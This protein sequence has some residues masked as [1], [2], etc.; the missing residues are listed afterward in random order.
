[1]IDAV[2]I[3]AIAKADTAACLLGKDH[4]RD[5][6]GLTAHAGQ[7]GDPVTLERRD[8]ARVLL[9][10]VIHG[11]QLCLGN[12]GLHPG[13]LIPGLELVRRDVD[14]RLDGLALVLEDDI[15][16]A[17]DGIALL[18]GQYFFFVRLVQQHAGEER[19]IGQM[20]ALLEHI[21]N[22]PVF[23]CGES[24]QRMVRRA[25]LGTERSGRS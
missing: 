7:V 2:R 14:P 21:M 11:V 1:M 5:G 9:D 3:G 25:G 17:R 23:F 15:G 13:N 24:I 16:L 18:P 8:D 6:N 19:L 12:G 10:H 4:P 20:A 22:G